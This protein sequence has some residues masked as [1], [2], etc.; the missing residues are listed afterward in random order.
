MSTHLRVVHHTP[1]VSAALDNAEQRQRDCGSEWG[2][3]RNAAIFLDEAQKLQQEARELGYRLSL[4]PGSEW[5][6]QLHRGDSLVYSASRPD[7]TA[8][9]ERARAALRMVLS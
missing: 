9:V 3:R 5:T 8:V 1:D 7:H 2:R 4:I 6:A